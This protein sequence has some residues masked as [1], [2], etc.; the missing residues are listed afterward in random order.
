MARVQMFNLLTAYG[1][2]PNTSLVGA[3]MVDADSVYR[4]KA[5]IV[6]LMKQNSVDEGR[7]FAKPSKGLEDGCVNMV[8]NESRPGIYSEAT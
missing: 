2:E 7:P 6:R 1:W 3:R 8:C 5:E 4:S